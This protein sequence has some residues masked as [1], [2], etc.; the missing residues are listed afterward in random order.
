[1][2]ILI[3]LCLFATGSKANAGGKCHYIIHNVCHHK[4]I[5]KDGLG[6]PYQLAMD[7]STNTLFFSISS[8]DSYTKFDSAHVNLIS[9]EF[10]IIEGLIGGFAHAVDSKTGTVY[11]GGSDGIYKFDYKT[12][13]AKHIDGSTKA[14][15][16]MFH[17]KHLYYTVYPEEHVYVYKDGQSQR[18]PRL[19]GTKAMLVAIDNDDNI[20]FSNSSGLFYKNSEYNINFLGDYVLNSITSDKNGNLYFSTP[21]EIYYVDRKFQKIEKLIALDDIY[22]VAIDSKGD[23]IYASEDSIIRLQPTMQQKDKIL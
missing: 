10:Q 2:W 9:K 13:T 21:S 23:V 19:N 5:I 7:Y 22:G 18:L 11:I 16:Q 20:Y 17:K 14:I 6:H 15:W 8:N 3:I 12:N 1:M 4:E